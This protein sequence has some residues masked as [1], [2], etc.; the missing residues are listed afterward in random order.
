MTVGV[1]KATL[2]I[3]GARSLKDRRRVVRSVKDRLRNSFN[4]SVCDMSADGLWHTAMLAV[5]AVGP[6]GADVEKR[7]T[8]VT[9]YLGRERDAVLAA[10]EREC[11]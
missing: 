2:H 7:L 10:S 1:L 4:V 3:P 5:A 6:N 8:S 11:Y 9:K